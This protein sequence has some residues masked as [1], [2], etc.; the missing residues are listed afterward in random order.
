MAIENIEKDLLI[1][2]YKLMVTSRYWDNNIDEMHA[3]KQMIGMSPHSGQGQEAIGVGGCLALNDE[4]YLVPSHRGCGHAITKGLSIKS[5]TADYLGKATGI[6]KG[7]GGAHICDPKN[8]ILGLSGI[9][10]GALLI[11]TGVGW[12]IK[13]R[14]TKQVVM[15]FFGDGMASQSDFYPALNISA[16]WKL[17]VIWMCE[18][19]RVQQFTHFE[20][21]MGM[22]NIADMG[23]PFGIPSIIVDGNDVIAVYKAALKAVTRARNGEGP[24]LIECKTYRWRPHYEGAPETRTVEELEE[25]KKKCPI[26]RLRKYLLQNNVITEDEARQIED[27]IMKEIKDAAQFALDSPWPKPEELDEDVFVEMEG[28]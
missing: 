22:G 7:K 15:D 13:I 26:D 5:L 14:K 19:N 4:D 17:P 16:A 18:N 24:S 8:N 10:G 2:M 25:M 12:S 27:N 6:T 21:V 9:L 23:K 20:D 28:E 3:K 1:K 11:A